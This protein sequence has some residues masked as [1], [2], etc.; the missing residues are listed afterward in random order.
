MLDVEAIFSRYASDLSVTRYLSWPRHHTVEDTHQFLA[1]SEQQWQTTS[2]GPLLIERLEDGVLLGS[3]GLALD[4]PYRAS[5]GYLLAQPYWG[6]GYASEVLTAMVALAEQSGL[7]RL[8]AICHHQHQASA[9]VLE[10]CGFTLEGT[11]VRHTVFPNLVEAADGSDQQA[12][13]VLMFG[14]ALPG[15]PLG[16]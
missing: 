3:T 14:L 9:R 11:L 1:F 8:E 5:T 7:Q 12:H 13:D 10:K 16:E 15:A 4:T 2:H 6:Q